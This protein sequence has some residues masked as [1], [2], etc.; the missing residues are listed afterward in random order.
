MIRTSFLC[1]AAILATGSLAQAEDAYIIKGGQA[2]VEI[3]RVEHHLHRM[4]TKRATKVVTYDVEDRI[5][6]LDKAR[7]MAAMGDD[8]D[9][10]IHVELVNENVLLDPNK[11]YIRQN[12]YAINENDLIPTAHRVGRDLRAN[13]ASI[14]FGGPDTVPMSVVSDDKPLMIIE[15][16]ENT[17]PKRVIPSV[18]APPKKIEKQVAM[19]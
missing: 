17:M 6:T 13:K 11:D 1:A 3:K 4:N 14:V 10:L 16:P 8:K 18:P 9:A 7:M 12:E 15:R 5:V 2:V 19:K